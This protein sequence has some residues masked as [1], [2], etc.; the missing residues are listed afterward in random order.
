MAA[1]QITD[2]LRGIASPRTCRQTS[3]P[4]KTGKFKSTRREVKRPRVVEAIDPLAAVGGFDDVV[5]F[6]FEDLGDQVAES[7]LV[8]DQ[9]Q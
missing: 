4:E 7:G 5:P 6:A 2:P 8:L 9:K 1:L 3:T